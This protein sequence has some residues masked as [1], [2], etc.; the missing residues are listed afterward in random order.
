MSPQ[1]VKIWKIPAALHA[2]SRAY[3][4]KN[5]QKKPKATV[6]LAEA[7]NLQLLAG[8]WTDVLDNPLNPQKNLEGYTY[9]D[10][11]YDIFDK[12]KTCVPASDARTQCIH[13]T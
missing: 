12:A 6:F 13:E 5:D 10:I 9:V 3:P 4:S 1:G 7:A 11:S 2:V 8:E